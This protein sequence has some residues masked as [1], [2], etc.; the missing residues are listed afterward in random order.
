MDL[1]IGVVGFGLR[2]H[3]ALEAHRPGE[4]S[5]VTAVCDLSE[6]SRTE[7]RVAF[8]DALI[9]PDLD[10]LLASGV[11]AVMVLTPDDTH[12]AVA[13]PALEAGAAVFC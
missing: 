10:H 2:G 9:T 13:V 5:V 7:A 4:G 1:K 3:L 11:D 12:A 6:R 8:P